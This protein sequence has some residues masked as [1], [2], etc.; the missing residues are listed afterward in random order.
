MCPFIIVSRVLSTADTVAA[1]RLGAHDVMDKPLRALDVCHA[2]Y[3]AIMSLHQSRT[4]HVNDSHENG[5]DVKSGSLSKRWSKAVLMALEADSD[6]KTLCKWARAAGMNS[7]SLRELCRL[8]G[9]R[10]RYA[11][12]FARML[13]AVVRARSH[14]CAPECM[15]DVGD[16]RTLRILFARAGLKRGSTS[17]VLNDLL[18]NQSFVDAEHPAFQTLCELLAP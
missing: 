16:E 4:R 8:L 15:L 1:M 17:I 14:Q 5:V 7:T 11:R 18:H 3:V 2:V 6:P 12:D 9:I 13:R 10:A